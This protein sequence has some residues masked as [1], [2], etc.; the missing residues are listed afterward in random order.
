[1]SVSSDACVVIHNICCTCIPAVPV[2]CADG[3][4]LM[5]I[6]V[7]NLETALVRFVSD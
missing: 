7:L 3:F 5:Q 2:P 4:V 6:G 1:M